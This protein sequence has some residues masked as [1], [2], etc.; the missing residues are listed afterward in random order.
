MYTNLLVSMKNLLCRPYNLNHN[1]VWLNYSVDIYFGTDTA[2]FLT[3]SR[4]YRLPLTQ[5]T[6]K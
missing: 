6:V 1:F 3:I 4:I 5:R 2:D